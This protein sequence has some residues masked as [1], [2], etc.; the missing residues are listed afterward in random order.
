MWHISWCMKARQES[1]KS[2]QRHY[3]SIPLIGAHQDGKVLMCLCLTLLIGGRTTKQNLGEYRLMWM[4]VTSDEL[5]SYLKLTMEQVQPSF[6]V[7][8]SNYIMLLSIWL[9]KLLCRVNYYQE[10]DHVHPHLDS[11]TAFRRALTTWASW[12]DRYIYPRQKVF[13]LISSPPHF[14]YAPW[15]FSVQYNTSKFQCCC[16]LFCASRLM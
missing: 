11:S 8:T 2:G 7:L 13:F 14:R 16:S 12:V 5:S 15:L 9:L 6:S 1:A 10:G 3:G 4:T